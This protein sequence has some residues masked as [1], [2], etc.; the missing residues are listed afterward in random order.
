MNN[1]P[2]FNL[3]TG[4]EAVVI[5]NGPPETLRQVARKY[6][7]DWIV[8]E[9]NHPRGLNS[10]YASPESQTWLRLAGTLTD[11]SGMP[12]YLFSVMQP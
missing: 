4:G 12:I 9:S 8:L 7:V 10:L 6:R 5:P 1:P 11:P 3:A 2:G